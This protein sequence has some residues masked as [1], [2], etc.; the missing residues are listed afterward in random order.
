MKFN[1][2][3][4]Y[5]IVYTASFSSAIAERLAQPDRICMVNYYRGND[6]LC[7]KA[8]M[9]QNFSRYCTERG[10]MFDW[11]PNTFV[12]RGS[13]VPSTEEVPDFSVNHIAIDQSM[14]ISRLHRILCRNRRHLLVRALFKPF[15]TKEGYHDIHLPLKR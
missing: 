13:R 6:E 8:R 15:M 12:I 9:A 10:V 5:S 1:Q 2:T 3:H 4:M 7:M 14:F 11:L